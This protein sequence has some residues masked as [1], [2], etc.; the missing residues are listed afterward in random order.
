MIWQNALSLNIP[1]TEIY[2]MAQY[3]KEEAQKLLSL[4]SEKIK[5]LKIKPLKDYSR[6]GKTFSNKPLT[7]IEKQILMENIKKLS[8]DHLWGVWNILQS[9][10][11]KSNKENLL[12]V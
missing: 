8:S 11:I 2:V 5:A 1:Q 3:M 9:D 4:P 10:S 12:K 7:N 6:K